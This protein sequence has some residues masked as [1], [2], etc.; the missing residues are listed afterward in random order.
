MCAR[1]ILNGAA[2][3][4]LVALCPCPSCAAADPT[5]PPRGPW[6]AQFPSLVSACHI[7][8]FLPWPED[9]L[10]GVGRRLLQ[11]DL[12]EGPEADRLLQAMARLHG[13]IQRRCKV[14]ARLCV[15]ARARVGVVFSVAGEEACGIPAARQ[16]PRRRGLPSPT[17]LQRKPLAT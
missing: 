3:R 8:W 2:A 17:P 5:I 4:A 14:L 12:A 9:A 15:H 7:T 1:Q 13:L 10:R 6:N 11:G 16:T